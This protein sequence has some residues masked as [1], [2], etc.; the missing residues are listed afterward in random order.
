MDG[1]RWHATPASVPPEVWRGLAA[2]GSRLTQALLAGLHESELPHVRALRYASLRRDGGAAGFAVVHL[3]EARD[4]DVLGPEALPALV[5]SDPFGVQ[6]GAVAHGGDAGA[7]RG[8]LVALVAGC[9]A[10]AR[11]LGAEG[12]LANA[13]PAAPN[14][15]GEALAAAGFT[16]FPD[17]AS[18]HVPLEAGGGAYPGAL[19]GSHRNVLARKRAQ[20]E[21][22]GLRLRAVGTD[23]PID[24]GAAERLYLQTAARKRAE[25]RY[26]VDDRL[27]RGFFERALGDPAFRVTA[28]EAPAGP[29]GV[30]V[31]AVVGDTLVS[32]AVGIDHAALDADR[33]APAVFQALHAHALRSAQA[34]GCRWAQLG[35]TALEGKA[36]L[37]AL[38]ERRS[39]GTLPLTERFRRAVAAGESAYP[40]EDALPS[41][42]PY[43]PAA[44]AAIA[45]EARQRGIALAGLP[46]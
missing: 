19:R 10:L 32:L 6:Q 11:E 9:V 27:C 13:L 14:P 21:R 5:I 39:M 2:S 46:P 22:N 44:L 38:F 42:R 31:C 17:D 30:L 25:Q 20:L 34:E 18:A 43:A 3:I 33:L 37:G 16:L 29:A 15:L 28:C 24:A 45:A 7:N 4:E 12:V 23:D 26:W 36:R 8:A 1:L 41:C 35:T 40:A